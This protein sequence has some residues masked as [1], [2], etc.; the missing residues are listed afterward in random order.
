MA[1]PAWLVMGRKMSTAVAFR[2]LF[3]HHAACDNRVISPIAEWIITAKIEK[4]FGQEAVMKRTV[5]FS[6]AA[7][8]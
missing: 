5:L 7:T 3:S 4:I 6:S 1:V 2:A 8:A